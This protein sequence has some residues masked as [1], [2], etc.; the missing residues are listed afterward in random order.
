M[1]NHFWQRCPAAN[2][3][4]EEICKTGQFWPVSGK[5]AAHCASCGY[6]PGL[7]W[8]QAQARKHGMISEDEPATAEPLVAK[9]GR[10]RRVVEAKTEEATPG[11]ET[12][13]E[14]EDGNPKA[15]TTGAEGDPSSRT[16]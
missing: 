12:S 15:A 1:D 5:Q 4:R 6:A 11:A 10:A 16:E 9:P 13:G 14:G 8:Q 3:K 7:P 2:A